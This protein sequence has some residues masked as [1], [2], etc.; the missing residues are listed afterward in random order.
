L[1]AMRNILLKLDELKG[2]EIPEPLSGEAIGIQL[3]VN[4][5]Y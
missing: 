3:G 5:I 1:K 2:E 4:S